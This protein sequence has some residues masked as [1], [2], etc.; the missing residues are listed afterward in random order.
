MNLIRFIPLLLLCCMVS[1]TVQKRKH[2]SGFY[3][4]WSH[5]NSKSNKAITKNTECEKK[6]V[7]QSV[8]PVSMEVAHDPGVIASAGKGVISTD[9]IA[10]RA[11]ISFT[12][13][14]CD[15]IVMRNG[16][17]VRA[18][19][20]ELSSTLIKYKRCDMIDG[21]L[22]TVNKSEVFMIKYPNGTKEVMPE[23]STAKQPDYR[24]SNAQ[25][26]VSNKDKKLEPFALI[27]F[28]TVIVAFLMPTIGMGLLLFLAGVIMCIFA[29]SKISNNP[30]KLKGKG[31]AITGLV[32]GL[33]FG[34][35]LLLYASQI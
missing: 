31:L 16:E 24:N 11:V 30:N 6:S 23:P 19:V 14:E 12:D 20:L 1:C 15:L 5:K 22:Y 3:V 27:G 8:E 35:L 26:P 9:I 4:S 13:T 2:Q 29:I 7:D 28:L 33:I 10:P 17:E 32:L 25:V 18:K 34:A 21:P